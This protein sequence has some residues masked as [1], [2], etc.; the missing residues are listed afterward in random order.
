MPR[1]KP[2]KDLGA[3]VPEVLA[4]RPG[5]EPGRDRSWD[6]QNPAITLRIR[7]Q[8]AA[9]LATHAEALGVAKDTLGAALLWAALDALE[10]GRLVLD[11]D[12]VTTEKTDKIG[13]RRIH[14]RRI[15][16]PAWAGDRNPNSGDSSG[17]L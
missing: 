7:E 14:T 17:S 8:D 12:Y 4:R 9:R 15:V 10:A 13:R 16:T 11:P 3:D 6:Q 5:Q 1:Q 2:F